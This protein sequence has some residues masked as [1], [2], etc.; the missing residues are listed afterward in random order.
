LGKK[1]F[2]KKIFQGHNIDLQ[3]HKKRAKNIKEFYEKREGNAKIQEM[4]EEVAQ[5]EKYIN[6]ISSRLKKIRNEFK[7]YKN[8]N[9]FVSKEN[10]LNYLKGEIEK[11]MM[12]KRMMTRTI[13]NQENAIQE[14]QKMEEDGVAER[15]SKKH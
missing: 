12:E 8:F 11:N 6:Q 15:V 4:N 9:E 2:L 3:L 13:D 14:T 7:E 1:F 5:Q 10:E